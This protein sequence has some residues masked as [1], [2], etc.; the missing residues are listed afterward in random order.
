M[1]APDKIYLDIRYNNDEYPKEV[2]ATRALES[3]VEYIRKDALLEWASQRKTGAEL[4]IPDSNELY[5]YMN[6]IK[7]LLTKLES[8]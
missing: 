2:F 4:T 8:L 6:A 5:G 7:A 3:D 1:N